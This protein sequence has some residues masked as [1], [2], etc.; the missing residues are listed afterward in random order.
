MDRTS[1]L[2]DVRSLTLLYFAAA[3]SFAPWGTLYAL[4]ALQGWGSPIL[5]LALLAGGILTAL[6]VWNRLERAQRAREMALLAQTLGIEVRFWWLSELP[7]PRPITSA[8]VK[9]INVSPRIAMV[10]GRVIE[11]AAVARP[12]SRPTQVST[13]VTQN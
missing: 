6:F 12:A 13:F 1:W 11:V 2:R 10:R 5:A 9:I 8:S 7:V 3:F 4:A